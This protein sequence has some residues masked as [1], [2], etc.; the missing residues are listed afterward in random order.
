MAGFFPG[1]SAIH[2]LM[3]GGFFGRKPHQPS[4]YEWQGLFPR[5][6][7]HSS[8]YEWRVFWQETPPTIKL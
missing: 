8:T 4:N 5:K 7:R 3:N 2:R 6:I 1:K